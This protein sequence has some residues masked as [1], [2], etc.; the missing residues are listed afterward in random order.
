VRK[1]NPAIYPKQKW[2]SGFAERNALLGLLNNHIIILALHQKVPPAATV[3]H[4]ILN[5]VISVMFR[6]SPPLSMPFPVHNHPPSTFITYDDIKFQT[7]NKRTGRPILLALRIFTFMLNVCSTKKRVHR[8]PE[9]ILY[10]PILL[11]AMCT[12]LNVSQKSYPVCNL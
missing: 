8:V 2:L 5:D 6:Y 11:F 10:P 4:P 12:I 1:F 7:N 3:L 9:P